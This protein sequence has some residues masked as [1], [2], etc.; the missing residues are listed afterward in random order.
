M[1]LMIRP[2]RP[3]DQ[4][5]IARIT[6]LAFDQTRGEEAQ[7]VARIRASADFIPELSLL[8]L[9]EGVPVGH[10]LISRERLR[11]PDDQ[12][13]DVGVLL[14]G[15]I[16][17]LPEYQRR[18]IGGALIHSALPIC[19]AR[20]EPAVVLVGHSEYYPRFG[21]RPAREFGLLPDWN[22]AMVYPLT[23]DLSPYASLKIPV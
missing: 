12:P 18:G 20:P 22:E 10:L 11:T 7:M 17:V 4:T 16:S 5:D 13:T 23:H 21:F 15:P 8:A 6:L 9:L 19:Q 3:G 1:T 2:E 14:L